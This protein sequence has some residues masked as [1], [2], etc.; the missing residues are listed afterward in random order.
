[1][2]PETQKSHLD[3]RY[4]IFLSYKHA[5]NQDQGR[6]WATWL[7]QILEGYEIPQDL[8]GT[9]NNKGEEIPPSLYPVFRDEE[10][11]PADADLTRN[12]EHALENS[13]LL[14]VI[15]SPLAAESRFVADEI[16]YFKEL[17][18]ADRVLALMI[19]GEP[20]A[21][22]DPAKAKL[23]I[24]PEAE[25]LP[26][27]LRYGVADTD[28]KIDWSKGTEPI[29]ADARPRGNPEQGWTSGAA[30]REALQR[31]GRLSGK[32]IAQE[33]GDYEQRLQLA[34]LKVIAGAIGVPLGIL[35]DRDVQMQLRKARQRSRALRRW[36]AAVGVLAVLAVAGGLSAWFQRQVAEAQRKEALYTG[37]ETDFSLAALK[38]ER[39]DWPV[40]L[41]YLA[42]ALR[43]NPQNQKAMVLAVSL[44]RSRP[45]PIAV[46]RHPSTVDSINFSPDG[47]WILTMS[48]GEARIWDAQTGQLV[49]QSMHHN[50]KIKSTSFSP[51]GQRVLTRSNGEARIWDTR[52]GRP[53]GQPM[54]LDEET[55]STS[56]SPDGKRVVTAFNDTVQ[57]WDTQTGLP[58]GTPMKPGGDVTSASFSPDGKS[59]V[60]ESQDK[61][62]S[63]TP[64]V[65]ADVPSAP[66]P[67]VEPDDS[68]DGYSL[69]LWDAKTGLPIGQPMKNNHGDASSANISLDG[70]WV[71][72]VLEETAQ[73][74]NA[75]T[76][77]P[78]GQPMKHAGAVRSVS[79]TPD[80]RRILLALGGVAR[81]WDQQTGLPAGSPMKGEFA[82]FSPDGRWVLT[83]SYDTSRVWDAQTGQP[84]GKPMK[85]NAT[86]N[87]FSAAFSP[88]SR[89]VVM[90]LPNNST[91]FWDAQ[92]GEPV[93]EPL[94]HGEGIF[95][96]SFSP[97]SKCVVTASHQTAQIR[98]AQ[99]GLPAGPPIQHVGNVDFAAFSP[100]G[101]WI[102]TAAD[103]NTVR[104]WQALPSEP[105]GLPMQHDGAVNSASSSRDG[106]LVLMEM[107]LADQGLGTMNVAGVVR[108]N[109]ATG[110]TLRVCD[111]LTGQ[112]VGQPITL[113][114]TVWS[115]EF[116]PDGKCVLVVL[117]NSTAQVWDVQTGQPRGELMKNVN[118]ASF[119]PDGRWVV[120]ASRDETAQV[121]DA[122]TG[123]PV[124]QLIKCNTARFSPDG[125]QV[126]T[127]L[128]NAVQVWD[129]QT[130]QPMGPLLKAGGFVT[131]PS[132]S[133]SPDSKSLLVVYGMSV[134]DTARSFGPRIA[135]VWNAQ[136]GQPIGPPMKQNE[137][138]SSANFSPNGK[139]VV[140]ASEDKT[141]QVWDAR[142][143]R[144]VG[145]PME[146]DHRIVSVCFSPDSRWVATGSETQAV[147]FWDAETG[148]PVT[149]PMEDINWVESRNFSPDGKWMVLVSRGTARLWRAIVE[150]Q[151]APPWLAEL[152]EAVGGKRLNS[153][154]VLEP[155][156]EDPARLR[157]D[158]QKLSGD[159][160]LS[161]FGRWI[162][163]GPSTRTIDPWSA[164]TMPDFIDARLQENSPESI[165]EAY[166]ADPGNPVVLASLA[167]FEK[168][169]DEALFLCRHSLKRA[170][171]E[172]GEA[173]VKKTRT[174]VLAAVPDFIE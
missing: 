130:G 55:T 137:N 174:I 156:P 66:G 120:T 91:C 15:C 118:R 10:E 96:M 88:N 22:N 148:Q 19:Y 75:R 45:L 166:S 155:S 105:V 129:A 127:V 38:M 16:R 9:I 49:G 124:G 93:G 44:I 126:V 27:P 34:K 20:N 59:V 5:D 139:Y 132:V 143:G 161:R 103:D 170:R 108:G 57:I 64:S 128:Q 31:Q 97:D 65:Q 92:T 87:V 114:H 99:T 69:R 100:D 119:S 7:H 86:G 63:S 46:M 12:I 115:K 39:K 138:I 1:M 154:G 151:Q 165:Q 58:V 145:H 83:V 163:A 4:A 106:K 52:T 122:L 135:Q 113:N 14:V 25:C 160:D 121:R 3:R 50:D 24:E 111:A 94:T 169:K 134:S 158:L 35:T 104:I 131:S 133:F 21:S 36:L 153:Q 60:T 26:Q 53:V 159:S 112:P 48:N 136:T 23:G 116:S 107:I 157:E 101:R 150:D 144:P 171:M 173:L 56:F 8:I 74:W 149:Q 167:K 77:Q 29:A 73:V 68:W 168:N 40:T 146:H 41:A 117:Q 61:P 37:S 90:A 125:K 142:T 62:E 102:M 71:V 42:D 70:R 67:D 162:A 109:A 17:G 82:R 80:G 110:Q 2:P 54:P 33:V 28:G 76:G 51:D 81:L 95:S 18:K 98:N 84:V 78:V 141:A 6:Q 11:L 140:T 152:A 47:K 147:R 79:F 164:I 43:K 13:E 85:G 72:T 123:Q 172:G 32:Q 89:W 30:Y